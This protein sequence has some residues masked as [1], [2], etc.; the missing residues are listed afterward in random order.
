MAMDTTPQGEDGIDML[1]GGFGPL[2]GQHS[3]GVERYRLVRG[4]GAP[5]DVALDH[6][7]LLVPL[8]SPT[9]LAREGDMV[10]AV[11]ENTG[12]IA[13][14]HLVRETGGWHAVIEG[15]VPVRGSGPTHAAV[16]VDDRGVRHLIAAN[17]GDG[18]LSVHG[19]GADG[20][21]GAAEQWLEGEGGGPLPAQQGPHAHWVLPL[22]DGRVL[23]TDLGADRIRVHRWSDGRL[24]RTGAVRLKPGTG[25]RDM[26][27]LPTRSDDWRVAVVDEWGCGVTV[28]RGGA[29]DGDDI[30]V[31]GTVDLGGDD[32]DQAA[33]LA[34]VPIGAGKV[35]DTVGGTAGDGIRGA[36]GYGAATIG[37]GKVDGGAASGGVASAEGFAYVGLRG[38]DRIVTLSWD[39]ESLT[40]LDHPWIAGWRGRGVSCGGGRPRQILAV[41]GLLVV[42]NETSDSL[43]VMAVG[44]DG[45]PRQVASVDAPS[46]TVVL[47]L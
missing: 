38:S 40:R 39:G 16:A 27:L 21:V 26:H 33:S 47:P 18:S 8:A 35:G 34:Y 31:V 13:S 2:N 7:G 6:L 43:A 45:E 23:S 37:D 3:R 19:M 4:V 14:L 36:V 12:E 10:Y 11:L 41:D 1:V 30:R 29:A 25:P 5:E 22:P 24:V 20:V 42:C 9:W 28:L 17:Y 32:A 46:P 44:A 15:T